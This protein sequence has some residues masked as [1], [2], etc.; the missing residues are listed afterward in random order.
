MMGRGGI[1]TPNTNSD[2]WLAGARARS[3]DGAADGGGRDARDVG[4]A[5]I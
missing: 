2:G 5:S 3:D 4:I 1:F